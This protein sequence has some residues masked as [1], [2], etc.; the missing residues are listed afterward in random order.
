MGVKLKIIPINT[1]P[2]DLLLI[3]G[4]RKSIWIF[5]QYEM[6]GGKQSYIK[7]INPDIIFPG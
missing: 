2:F 7:N 1:D 5:N 3:S 4:S 6:N